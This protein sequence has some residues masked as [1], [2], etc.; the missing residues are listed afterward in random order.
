MD[1]ST[2]GGNYHNSWNIIPYELGDVDYFEGH[3]FSI[4]NKDDLYPF[5]FIDFENLELRT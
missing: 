1:A 2:K 4:L 5:L 3:I